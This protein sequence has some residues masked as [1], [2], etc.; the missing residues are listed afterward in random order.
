MLISAG[1]PFL[2]LTR[3]KASWARSRM[4]GDCRNPRCHE[5]V[6]PPTPPFS[7]TWYLGPW[8]LPR[9]RQV[10][11]IA[12][13]PRRHFLLH[14]PMPTRLGPGHGCCTPDCG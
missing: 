3:S 5:G 2:D 11:A 9:A 10:R 14:G 6:D 4:A 13:L 8:N 7:S 12:C 1:K